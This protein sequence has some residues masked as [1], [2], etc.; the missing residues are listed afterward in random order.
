MIRRSGYQVCERCGGDE[1]V[2]TYERGHGWLCV[3][4]DLS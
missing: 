2:T 1:V 4:A 3:N